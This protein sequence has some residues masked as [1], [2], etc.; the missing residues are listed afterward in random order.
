[1]KGGSGI[2]IQGPLANEDTHQPGGGA[3]LI[4]MALPD[5]RAVRPYRGRGLQTE[6]AH[7]EAEEEPASS[8]TARATL[9]TPRPAI[10]TD[11]MISSLLSRNNQQIPCARLTNLPGKMR[12]PDSG[13]PLNQLMASHKS[14]VRPLSRTV[15]ASR[16]KVDSDKG[17][18]PK[19]STS[20]TFGENQL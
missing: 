9:S 16:S 18:T 17:N 15:T 12:P 19:V 8:A 6:G 13:L 20:L 4:T 2:R 11:S 7:R 3:R 1:M 10:L 5:H 14:R